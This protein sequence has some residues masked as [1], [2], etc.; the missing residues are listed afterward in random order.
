MWLICTQINKFVEG[1]VTSLWASI[2]CKYEVFSLV[3]MNCSIWKYA[4][5]LFF[6][7]LMGPGVICDSGLRHCWKDLVAVKTK[8]Y[9]DME[10]CR[11]YLSTCQRKLSFLGFIYIMRC[12]TVTLAFQ[13]L[14]CGEE[15]L[16]IPI[17]YKVKSNLT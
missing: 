3:C 1:T 9:R 10:Q 11:P 6:T 12:Q 8:M 7:H 16:K 13:E 15:P 17:K 5:R 4:K 14:K 2:A